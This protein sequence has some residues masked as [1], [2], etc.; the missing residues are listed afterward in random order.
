MILCIFYI[1]LNTVKLNL[2]LKIS[3]YLNLNKNHV[4]IFQD[5]FGQRI[6]NLVCLKITKFIFLSNAIFI[7]F[8]KELKYYFD[9]RFIDGEGYFAAVADA[10]KKAKE[11]IFITDWWYA[12]FSRFKLKNIRFTL[13]RASTFSLVYVVIVLRNKSLHY[14]RIILIIEFWPWDISLYV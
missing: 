2:K 13:Y 12:L 4:K 1:Q 5:Q 3:R 8:I 14:Y 6:K 7:I 9:Y 11:E 10:I